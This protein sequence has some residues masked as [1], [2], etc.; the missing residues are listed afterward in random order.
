MAHGWH[1]KRIYHIL[2]ANISSRKNCAGASFQ[3]SF[4]SLTP[5]THTHTEREKAISFDV[6]KPMK[7]AGIRKCYPFAN[8]EKCA[9]HIQGVQYID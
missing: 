2:S 8:S 7:T 6:V 3:Q 5:Y 4:F 1:Y 9:F